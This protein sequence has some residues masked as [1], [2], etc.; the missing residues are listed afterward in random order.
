M[1]VGELLKQLEEFPHNT[2]VV[3]WVDNEYVELE[4]VTRDENGDVG[5]NWS[6]RG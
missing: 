2:E 5:I 4:T 3:F 6:E 1:T